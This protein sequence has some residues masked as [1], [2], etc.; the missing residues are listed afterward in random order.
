MIKV[1]FFAKYR[2]Q[3]GTES[4][5]L[6]NQYSSVQGLIEALKSKGE[7]WQNVFSQ[8]G[9]MVAVNQAMAKHDCPL[10]DG[11]EVAF[12]PPVTGG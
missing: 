8:S 4:L 9:L 2:E 12:F 5:Q 10:K 11:D 6:D 7:Q 3:L 1:L